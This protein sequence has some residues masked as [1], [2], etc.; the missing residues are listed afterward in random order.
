MHSQNFTEDNIKK[1]AELFPSCVTEAS[2][3]A[4]NLQKS[5]DFDQ[6]K[7]ELSGSI[8]DGTRERYHL[9]WVGKREAILAGNAPTA[10]TLRPMRSESV[11]FDTT[12]NVFIRG[13]N[14]DA[15]KLLQETYLNRVKFI[16]IDPPYNTGGDFIYH[17]D[18]KEDVNEYLANSLQVDSE[19]RKLV[20]TSE[21]DGRFHSS[22]LSMIYPRIRLARNLLRDDGVIFISIDD[23]EAG[24]LKRVCDEVFGENSF[25]SAISWKKR[26][27]PDAR[28]TVGSV[29]DTI[30]C[31][32]K[33]GS[34]PKRAV[35]KMPLSEKR[36]EA[37][38]NPDDDSRGSWASVDMTGMIGRATK[39][40]FF[41]VTL[42]SG[43]V[44]EPPEGRSWGLAEATYNELCDDNRIWF[45][46]DG[47]NVPR[48]K[49]FLSES[50][51]QVVPSLWDMND[52]GSNDE[53]SKEITELFEVPKLF[54]TPKPIRLI[55][56]SYTHLTLPTILL[57]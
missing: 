40:Q 12:K 34:E 17:D 3:E 30:L 1:L 49:K 16:Y 48:I 2:D 26:S 28:A 15:L 14:M 6:L 53:A 32:V 13:D 23:G 36:K 33:D 25:L 8:V 42:P 38:T 37:F 5:I 39:D 44:I 21:T 45:G 27:S 56:V 24:N 43:R 52:C 11:E 51:G 54:D 22:W 41:K 19:G 35:G 47:D 4:G 55:A 31:Y 50:T 57:V 18:F 20:A 46:R 10:K 9:N 7:Q 29:H